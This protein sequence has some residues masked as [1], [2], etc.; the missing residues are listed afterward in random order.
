MSDPSYS[1]EAGCINLNRTPPAEH[2]NQMNRMDAHT[3]NHRVP[4]EI[5]LG[6]SG[7][8][9]EWSARQQR[10]A[11]MLPTELDVE[12]DIGVDMNHHSEIDSVTNSDVSDLDQSFEDVPDSG[13]NTPQIQGSP[14]SLVSSPEAGVDMHEDYVPVNLQNAQSDPYEGVLAAESREGRQPATG[15]EFWINTYRGSLIEDFQEAHAKFR[16]ACAQMIL[17]DNR[18]RETRLRIRRADRN[19]NRPVSYSLKQ[20]ISVWIGVKMMFF[21][22]SSR[23][24]DEMDG[25]EREL[26]RLQGVLNELLSQ[27]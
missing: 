13:Q 5:P 6:F 1:A 23:L 7:A 12:Y 11:E 14:P 8:L 2:Q 9:M 17:L 19:R 15:Q 4:S 22:Y 27:E 24:A 25:L 3:V 16:R 18:I 21:E 20:H 26:E 10:D